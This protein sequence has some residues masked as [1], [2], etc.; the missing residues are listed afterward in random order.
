[1][2][3][4]TGGPYVLFNGN[5]AYF[6]TEVDQKTGVEDIVRSPVAIDV[7]GNKLILS[8]ETLGAHGS[9]DA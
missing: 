7:G 8:L 6:L 3:G 4:V 9:E 2:W 1:M 5:D